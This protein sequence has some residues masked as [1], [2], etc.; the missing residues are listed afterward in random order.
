MKCTNIRIHGH[1]P[2]DCQLRA[3]GDTI[4]SQ[5]LALGFRVD[6]SP[7]GMA[8][9]RIGSHQSQ[10]RIVPVVHGYNARLGTRAKAGYTRTTTPTW[11]QRV[12][13][14]LALNL[15]LDGEHVTCHVRSG[16]F[17]LRTVAGGPRGEADWKPGAIWGQNRGVIPLHDVLLRRD[18][19]SEVATV[20][21]PKLRL[22]GGSR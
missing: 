17:I 7:L 18:E 8:G 9:L 13:F 1:K 11:E 21:Y 3:L 5:L 10:F 15:V 22:V 14:N 19:L 16:P 6:A 2:T 4:Q 20:E 12:E